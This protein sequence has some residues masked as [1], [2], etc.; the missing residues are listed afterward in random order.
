MIMKKTIA[1]LIVALLALIPIVMSIASLKKTDEPAVTTVKDLLKDFV[2]KK[3][4][5]A[6]A[7]KLADADNYEM[8]YN[9]KVSMESTS[10]MSRNITEIRDGD[11]LYYF[12]KI[13]HPYTEYTYVDGVAYMLETHVINGETRTKATMTP[14]ELQKLSAYERLD[15]LVKQSDS[16]FA[17][18]TATQVG[19]TVVL[20]F[21]VSVEEMTAMSGDLS[22]DLVNLGT[23]E[24]S[25]QFTKGT[26]SVCFNEAYEIIETRCD[27]E[28]TFVVARITHTGKVTI[29]TVISCDDAKVEVPEKADLYTDMTGKL[30][31]PE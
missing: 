13:G 8:Y 23:T 29:R 7:K 26:Y 28:M 3:A 24:G 5:E 17:S 1:V 30:E 12:P 31:I 14:E 18:A 27:F 11:N 16:Q 10:I 22:S 20:T 6:A 19:N 4:Y 9:Y 15:V 2:P 25:L 21:P